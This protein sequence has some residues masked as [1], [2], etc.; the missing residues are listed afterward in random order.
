MSRR[1]VYP[2]EDTG[3]S[4][5]TLAPGRRRPVALI[6]VFW[7]VPHFETELIT[8][9][10]SGVLII[11]GT[12]VVS[13][14]PMRECID[15]MARA[16]VALATADA[17]VPLRTLMWLPEH[18][19]LLGMMPAFYGPARVMGIK[20]VSVMP[21]NHGTAFD[22]H[23]GA[24]IIFETEH[25]CPLAIVD[26]S[27]ITAIRTAAVSGVATRLLARE[28]AR[29]LA[30]LGSGTQAATHLEAMLCVRPV[31]RVRVWSRTLVNAKQFAERESKR[32]RI[33]VLPVASAADAVE[34]A[35]VICT[36]TSSREPVLLGDWIAPGAHINAVGSSVRTARELDATAIARSRL[37]VDRRESTLNEAGDFLLARAEGAVSD[38]HIIG[39]IGDV[40][41]GRGGGRRSPQDIT[42]FESLGLGIEDVAAAHYVYERAREQ[43]RGASIPLGGTHA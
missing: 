18:R 33:A 8:P 31:E 25:G 35:D 26:A 20:V 10:N 2:D 43:Q 38:D 23:Q 14:L 29:D 3:M 37:F 39:E 27:A 42:L 15:V 1:P 21:G 19:G 17:N 13:L 9:V 7:Y 6:P 28:D 32:H 30:I 41:A 5:R 24:V 12:E 11:D 16:L 36:T 40:L 4:A 34:G 22:A